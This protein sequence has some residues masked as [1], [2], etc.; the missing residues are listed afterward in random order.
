[1]PVLGSNPGRRSRVGLGAVA[2]AIVV[3]GVAVFEQQQA[4]Q[5]QQ[6]QVAGPLLT[7]GFEDQGGG[8][9]VPD[10]CTDPL[11]QPEGF[12]PLSM[13]WAKMWS[14]K[15]KPPVPQMQFPDSPGFP[16]GIGAG[17]GEYQATT[18]TPGA[19]MG[20]TLYFERH[21]AGASKGEP[22]GRP[23]SSM[24]L[25]I[26]PCAGDFRLRQ[27]CALS[28]YSGSLVWTTR[29][30]TPGPNAC[31]LTAGT[32]YHL[33]VAPVDPSDGSIAGDYT[34]ENPDAPYCWVQ[35]THRPQ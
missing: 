6:A 25:S 26:S 3:G 1:M 29:T 15:A 14:S 31:P 33:I 16:V 13:T 30:A 17:R 4:P 10:A 24:F 12:A 7:D 34:C 18:F 9:G 32:T 28:T 35:A 21:Q 20:A 8:G 5:V 19:N 22:M 11:V 23:A 27:G 2:V